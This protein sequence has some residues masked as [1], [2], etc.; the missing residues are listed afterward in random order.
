MGH[1]KVLETNRE[2][3]T[4]VAL[5]RDGRLYATL[6]FYYFQFGSEGQQL[7]MQ[8]KTAIPAQRNT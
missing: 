7:W 4:L 8:A 3:G 1:E 5:P 6:E 2:D